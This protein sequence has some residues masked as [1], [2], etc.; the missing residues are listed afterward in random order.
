MAISEAAFCET[1]CRTASRLGIRVK[2]A[3]RPHIYAFEFILPDGR[4]VRGREELTER[5]ALHHACVKLS[6]YLIS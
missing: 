3:G 5:T 2:R 4:L 6:P 1:V